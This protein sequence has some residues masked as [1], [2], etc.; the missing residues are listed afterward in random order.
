MAKH[1][2]PATE[3]WMVASRKVT[4]ETVVVFGVDVLV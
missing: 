4:A 3:G 2:S 1:V